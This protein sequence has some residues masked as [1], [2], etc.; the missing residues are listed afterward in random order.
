MAGKVRVVPLKCPSCSN[1]LLGL[2]QDR[3]FFCA[4]CRQSYELKSSGF[5]NRPLHF[6]KPIIQY[7]KVPVIYLPFYKFNV[8]FIAE[9][10]DPKQLEAARK[11]KDLDTIWV[12]GF[13]LI[14]ASYFGDLGLLYTQTRTEI[15]E[16]TDTYGKTDKFRIAGCARTL[17]EAKVYT[18]LFLLLIMSSFFG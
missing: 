5:K 13:N 15:E 9:S 10:D 12:M 17:D 14:R 18:K 1:R 7:P 11:F 4:P 16:E 2:E 3:I 8:E 6:A